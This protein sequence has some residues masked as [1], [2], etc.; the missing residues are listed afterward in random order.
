MSVWPEKLAV[1]LDAGVPA[2]LVTV[3]AVKGSA[4]RE[5]GAAM[6]VTERDLFGTVGGGR[7]E[8]RAARLAR[9]MLRAGA[10]A[11]RREFPLGPEL[12]QCCGGHVA[13]HFRPV[14]ERDR[15]WL[16]PLRAW[17][18]AGRAAA[19]VFAADG[20]GC[21]AVSGDD[22]AGDLGPRT[23]AA[24]R[25]ARKVLAGAA[26]ADD[27]WHVVRV[28]P[29]DCVVYLFGAGHVGRALASILGQLPCRAVWID[30]R[31]DAFPPAVPANV[32]VVRTPDPVAEAKRAAK[33]AYVLVMTHSH[34]R[35]QQIVE[36]VLRRGDFAYLGLI[37]SA[38][39]RARFAARLRA[40]GIGEAAL[41]RLVCP[42]GAEGIPGKEPGVIALAAAAEI[43]RR[44]RAVPAS[45]AR[46]A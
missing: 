27:A 25:A 15:A 46:S 28:I 26:A 2:A 10:P 5:A 43:M 19:L 22:V 40:S 17:I 6:I 9:A 11:Q 41:A 36:A 39:K 42:I 30:E 38:T 14:S 13:L 18:A 1:L 32:A 34:A 4:P 35:D 3:A 20:A 24:V 8:Y 44:H 37:G 12:G 29:P 33:G 31:K 16:E 7:L 45:L 23:A 21:L